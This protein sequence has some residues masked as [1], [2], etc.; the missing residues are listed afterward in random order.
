MNPNNETPPWKWPEDAEKMI[1]EVLKD[2]LTDAAD[3]ILA[4]ELAGDLTVSS[5]E[6]VMEREKACEVFLN[7]RTLQS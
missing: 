1:L 6:L 7:R 4:G 2:N 5:D 3:L